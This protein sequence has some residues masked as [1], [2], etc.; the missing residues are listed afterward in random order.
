MTSS[1]L[2]E[3]IHKLSCRGGRVEV[4]ED[5]GACSMYSQ[6]HVKSL[7]TVELIPNAS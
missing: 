3:F 1:F 4:K 5:K 6:S 7:S 2:E